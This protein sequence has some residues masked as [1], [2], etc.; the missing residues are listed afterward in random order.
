MK[1]KNSINRSKRSKICHHNEKTNVYAFFLRGRA[2]PFDILGY[3]SNESICSG[4]EKMVISE[5]KLDNIKKL[6]AIAQLED[7]WNA[8]GANAFAD[9]LITKS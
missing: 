6:E 1:L 4:I 2:Y 3:S 5:E 7:N 8:N 9:S